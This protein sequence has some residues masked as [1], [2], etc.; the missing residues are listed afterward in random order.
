VMFGVFSVVFLVRYRASADE[1]AED[2]H[3]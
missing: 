3:A 2:D 1:D